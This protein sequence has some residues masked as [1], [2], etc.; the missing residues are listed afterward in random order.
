MAGLLTAAF[1]SPLDRGVACNKYAKNQ[2][3]RKEFL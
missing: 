1:F 2:I 3:D